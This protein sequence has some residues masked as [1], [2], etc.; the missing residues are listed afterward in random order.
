VAAGSS[1]DPVSPG[2]T[3]TSPPAAVGESAEATPKPAE[4]TEYRVAYGVL[5]SD[6]RI[7]LVGNRWRWSEQSD[8][9]WTLPGG[10][11]EPGEPIL[12]ALRREFHEETG[13]TIEPADL[14]F[15][16]EVLLPANHQ[17]FVSFVFQVVE[18]ETL[19]PIPGPDDDAVAEVRF[20]PVS[21]VPR[22]LSLYTMQ[23]PIGEH[24]T[25]PQTASRF[26]SF[27]VSA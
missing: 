24:L 15:V 7:L 23:V 19:D 11:T 27:T 6:E 2:T 3:G 16:L 18:T 26:Y 12:D 25:S 22:V 5:R 10:R 9:V 17:R 13:L 20:V 14:L 21:E 8:L 1:P 4:W